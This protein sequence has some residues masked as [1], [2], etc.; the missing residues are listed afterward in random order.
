MNLRR[1]EL[2]AFLDYLSHEKRYSPLTVTAYQRDLTRLLQFLTVEKISGW[3]TLTAKQLRRYIAQRHASGMQGRSLQRELSSARSF[4]R[5]LHRQGKVS[6]N[7]AE[8]LSAPRSAKRL[9]KTLGVDQVS[10]LLEIKG[11]DPLTLRDRAIMELL[12]SSGLRLAEIVAL[13]CVDADLDSALVSVRKGKGAKARVI[14]MGRKAIAALQDWLKVRPGLKNASDAALFLSQRGT[15]LSHRAIQKRLADWA[16]RQGL[17]QHLHPHR[18]R[19]AFATHLLESSGDIRAVQELLGHANISSTQI[20]TQ[21][22][23]QHLTTVYD[24]A[25]PRARRQRE[26]KIR[27]DDKG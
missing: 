4:Y 12:Y 17:E 20:Y 3:D 18:L 26:K 2:Q 10:R 19:H 27:E 6:T 8:N 5:Y 25:H 24:Q 11:R 14:P 23:F 7:P 16:K 22:D 13:D 1:A 9:P 21:L 15:R